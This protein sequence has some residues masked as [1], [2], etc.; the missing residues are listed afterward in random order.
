MITKIKPLP[1]KKNKFGQRVADIHIYEYYC[2]LME[3]I[4]EAH[5]AAVVYENIETARHITIDGRSYDEAIELVDIITCCVTRLHI[6]GGKY[7]ARVID[8]PTDY[9][10][11]ELA[12]Q[13]LCAFQKAVLI[14]FFSVNREAVELSAV[15]KMCVARLESLG[16]DESARENLYAAV[17]DKNKKRGYFEE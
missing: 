3:E 7:D 13:V 1:V 8:L 17:N 4:L 12:K 15:I 6:I 11:R 9:F 14:G 5:K 10:Y 16:Y 2:Q